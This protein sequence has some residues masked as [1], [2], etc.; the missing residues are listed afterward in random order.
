MMR[1]KQKY[2]HH[3]IY[4]HDYEISNIDNFPVKLQNR[5]K[6]NQTYKVSL[7]ISRFLRKRFSFFDFQTK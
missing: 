2:R 6:S 3:M 4:L 1:T 7:K 5:C